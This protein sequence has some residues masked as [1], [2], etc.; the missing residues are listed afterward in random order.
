MPIPTP[1][2]SSAASEFT[3][4]PEQYRGSKYVSIDCTAMLCLQ[5]GAI[6]FMFY[7]GASC[8]SFNPL[9]PI[10]SLGV[11]TASETWMNANDN[12]GVLLTV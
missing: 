7:I 5:K 2:G 3:K 4:Q 12:R 11:T 8:E 1:T 9:C 6:I 10:Y